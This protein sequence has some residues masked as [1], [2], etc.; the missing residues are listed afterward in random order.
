MDAVADFD[1]PG[2]FERL[3]EACQDIQ[4]GTNKGEKR[5][6]WMIF[7]SWVAPFTWSARAL[8]V[9]SSSVAKGKQPECRPPGAQQLGHG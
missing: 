5:G 8:G 3:L 4:Q 6:D 2:S 7:R 1:T 9:P